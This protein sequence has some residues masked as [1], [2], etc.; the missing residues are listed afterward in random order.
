MIMVARIKG[1]FMTALIVILTILSVGFCISKSDTEEKMYC[2]FLLQWED[3][4]TGSTTNQI[5]ATLKQMLY[6]VE[7]MESYDFMDVESQCQWD[8]LSILTFSSDTALDKF[9]NHPE[10]R[11]LQQLY[12]EN[13]KEVARYE[14]KERTGL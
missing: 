5:E 1:Y 2:V 12:D 11:Q 6:E 4:V 14:Y 8:Q 13:A 10:Y 9:M 7:G 3:D